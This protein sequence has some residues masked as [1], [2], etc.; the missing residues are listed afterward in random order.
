MMGLRAETAQCSSCSR[1]VLSIGLERRKGR[2]QPW[3]CCAGPGAIQPISPA[4]RHPDPPARSGLGTL[5]GLAT[6]A[7]AG[8][9][10]SADMPCAF[11][12]GRAD[13]NNAESSSMAL[14]QELYHSILFNRKC[15]SF[16]ICLL[17]SKLLEF[18][19]S[20]ASFLFNFKN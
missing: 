2:I 6:E 3:R 15:M 20:F 5:S 14:S 19:T 8:S 7:F 4:S 1:V 10:Q 12:P 13:G 18:L 11:S 16:F 9:F 17:A